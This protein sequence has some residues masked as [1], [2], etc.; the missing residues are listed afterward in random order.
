MLSSDNNIETIAQLVESTKRYIG[1]KSEYVKLDIIEKVVRLL[2]IATITFIAF[3]IVL[4]MLIYVSFAI[5]YAL[6]PLVGTVWAFVIVAGVYLLILILFVVKRR[7]W[8]EKPLVKFLAEL[9]LSK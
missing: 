3:F 7:S 9:L 1:V 8:I 6:A 4:L 5:A 2:T